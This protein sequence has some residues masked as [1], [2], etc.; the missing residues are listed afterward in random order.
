[1]RSPPHKHA[2]SR[3]CKLPGA[4]AIPLLI[5]ALSSFFSPD[6]ILD[7]LGVSEAARAGV[8]FESRRQIRRF[9]C[10]AYWSDTDEAEEEEKVASG[11]GRG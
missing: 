3:R 6:G 4:L 7:V 9:S 5:R 1:M 2:P 10:Y 8:V 11:D